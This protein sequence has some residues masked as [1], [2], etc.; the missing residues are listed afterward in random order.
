MM[1]PLRRCFSFVVLVLVL[2]HICG[3]T[4]QVLAPGLVSWP[5]GPCALNRTL[6]SDETV[7]TC[8]RRDM[9]QVWPLPIASD[10]LDGRPLNAANN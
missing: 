8:F 1:R 3:A 5:V 7:L 2:L 4:G 9:V 6:N 10:L